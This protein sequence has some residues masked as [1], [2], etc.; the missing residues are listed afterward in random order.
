VPAD[1][2]LQ[3]ASD[4]VASKASGLL[5]AATRQRFWFNGIG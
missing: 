3:P 2:A 1:A 4:T 5:S